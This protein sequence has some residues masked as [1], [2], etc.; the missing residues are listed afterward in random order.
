MKNQRLLTTAA[1]MAAITSIDSMSAMSCAPSSDLDFGFPHFGP[2]ER[3]F[4]P[5]TYDPV[6]NEAN[7]KIEL[8]RIDLGPQLKAAAEARRARRAAAK[9]SRGCA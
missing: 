9:A 6:L 8:A 2:F 7:R 3:P 5:T 4:I 1:A